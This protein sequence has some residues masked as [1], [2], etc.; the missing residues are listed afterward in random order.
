MSLL[1][2]LYVKNIF[3]M[4]HFMNYLVSFACRHFNSVCGE[5]VKFF[6]EDYSTGHIDYSQLLEEF[7]YIP[8]GT[9]NRNVQHWVQLYNSKQLKQFDH[10]IELNYLKYGQAYPPN[11]EITN[12]KSYNVKSLMTISKAD[13]FSKIEDCQHLFEHLD[14]DVFTVLKLDDYNHLDYLWSS[15]AQRDLYVEVIDFL[16]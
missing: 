12:F 15:H 6:I 5:I 7:H 13:P 16:K 8:G 4:P 11:Y 10:G 1:E 14:P 9:S 2:R 3:N